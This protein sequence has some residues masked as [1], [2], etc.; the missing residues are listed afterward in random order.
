MVPREELPQLSQVQIVDRIFGMDPD[1]SAHWQK[2]PPRAMSFLHGLLVLNP[3]KRLTATEALDHSWFKKPLSEAALLEERYEKVIR[4]WR[5]RDDDEMIENLSSR[6]RASQ[7]DQIVASASKSRRKVADITP[8]PYFGLDR[9]LQPKMASKRKM[10]LDSLNESGSPFLVTEQNQ[11]KTR[12][13]NPTT[14]MRDV[15]SIETVRGIDLFGTFRSSKVASQEESDL[16]EICLVPTTPF[17]P[18]SER[19]F[20]FD[21]SDPL[22]ALSSPAEAREVETREGSGGIGKR[23]RSRRESEDAEERSIRDGVAKAMPR[24]CTAKALKDAVEKR[25]RETKS[26]SLAGLAIRNSAPAA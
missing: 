9:H 26:C 15:V 17:V 21:I 13:A 7:E 25:K 11:H 16:D 1:T 14:Q 18:H 20:G 12:V 4:F 5:K 22:E 6:V 2:L 23:K 24:Y 8:S 3:D 19:E 10:I